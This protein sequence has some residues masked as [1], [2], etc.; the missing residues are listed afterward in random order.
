[1]S[2]AKTL[3]LLFLSFLL[4]T[5]N[6]QA[7]YG[8]KASDA[9]AIAQRSSDDQ[10][11]TMLL[12][13]YHFNNPGADE[14]NVEVDDYFSAKRQAEIAEVV[15][16]LAKFKPTKIFVEAPASVQ[17]LL[18]ERFNK[19]KKGELLLKDLKRG[20]SET[21]QIGFQVAKACDLEGVVCID[22]PGAWLGKQMKETAA[23]KMPNLFRE[24]DEKMEAVVADEEKR[25]ET[26]TV[27]ENLIEFNTDASIMENHSYYNQ[28]AVLVAD[29]DQ[30]AGL[31]FDKKSE[32]GVETMMIGVEAQNIG[33]ELVGKWYTRNIKI[34]SKIV[35][36]IDKEDERILVIF[37]QGHIRPIKHFCED[38][39]TFKLV[40]PNVFLN[41]KA[42]DLNVG[43]EVK[44]NNKTG[45][46]EIETV[47]PK[48]AKPIEVMVLGTF[49]FTQRPKGEMLTKRRQTE[50][51]EVVACLKKFKPAKVFVECNPE[52]AYNNNVDVAYQR[53]LED[54]I[55]LPVNEI[56]D[57]GFRTA[58]ELGHP[59]V[60]QADHP[61]RYGFFHSKAK[62][63][64]EKHGQLDIL[65]G[66]AVGTTLGLYATDDRRDLQD[67]NQTVMDYLR[68][69][70]GA[71]SQKADH[72][73]YVTRY[74]RLGDTAPPTSDEQILQTDK[75]E[76]FIGA[77]LVADWYRRNIMI[78]SKVLRE[79][80]YKEERILLIFGSGHA[81]TLKHLFQS[82]PHF[83]VVDANQWLK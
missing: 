19:F 6:A 25:M 78:Y 79:V 69:L 14:Y 5:E 60:Y 64:A 48:P 71:A 7:Q 29:P 26:T 81:P 68:Y 56:F 36:A 28:M 55:K 22:A 15:S 74:P 54:K 70:N 44:K 37:G 61:G 10:I 80:D 57:L 82:N 9:P 35:R 41:P 11:Q 39:P 12:G 30:P 63:Y 20:R 72:A 42:D 67:D 4:M 73:S 16:R 65:N 34:F 2:R 46:L 24:L 13:T 50:I 21:Y 59:Q 27:L 31:V 66:K 1:M 47:T 17:S 18:D 58:R 45:D 32:A 43:S 53:F 3:F 40:E 38:H 75:D 8:S 51:A 62:A 33:A 77:E 83:K 49:H 23:R 76:Y 52:F